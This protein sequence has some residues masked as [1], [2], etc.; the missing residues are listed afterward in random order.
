MNGWRI[1]LYGFFLLLCGWRKSP[2]R[3]QHYH[4]IALDADG[5]LFKRSE[6]LYESSQY[7]HP[8]SDSLFY[9]GLGNIHCMNAS[10]CESHP[11]LQSQIQ[12]QLRHLETAVLFQ[13]SNGAFGIYWLTTDIFRPFTNQTAFWRAY[14]LFLAET[15]VC[16]TLPQN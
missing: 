13:A 7:Q 1:A 15:R 10:V 11:G 3:F 6:I 12:T 9:H 2:T 4:I 14:A 5:C 8:Q 16:I